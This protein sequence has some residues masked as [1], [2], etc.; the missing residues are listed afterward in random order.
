MRIIP[1]LISKANL[2]ANPPPCLY[3]AMEIPGAVP[4]AC[5]VIAHFHNPREGIDWCAQPMCKP[6]PRGYALVPAIAVS[7]L[8]PPF[9]VL[10]TDTVSEAMERIALA[11]CHTAWEVAG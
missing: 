5:L 3:S 7:L 9:G 6:M 11:G 1:V 8:G 2:D 4:A 10:A